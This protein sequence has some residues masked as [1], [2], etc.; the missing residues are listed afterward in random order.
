MHPVPEY[1]ILNEVKDRIQ[2]LCGV[3][4]PQSTPSACIL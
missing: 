3:D 1:V 4:S 2:Y